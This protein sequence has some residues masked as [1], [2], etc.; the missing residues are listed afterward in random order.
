M[1]A[2]ERDTLNQ[3]GRTRQIRAGE[4]LFWQGD[5]EQ[6]VANVISGVMKVTSATGDGREQ[7]LGILYP[8][9]FVG[10]PF[11]SGNAVTVTALTDVEV[12]TFARA[13]FDAFARDHPLLEHRLLELTFDEL[14]RAREWMLLL[15]RKSADERLAAFLLHISDRLRTA[16]ACVECAGDGERFTL[17]FGR[18]QIADMLA[19]T[20][21]TVS[22]RMTVMRTKGYIDTPSRREVIIRDRRGLTMLAA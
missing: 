4:T 18:Q 9:D 10:R 15:G 20:I 19:L 6:A 21:E 14:D 16:N 2:P 17:P 3:L 12:C 13:D 1:S 8:A 11:T 22:R 7:T 5:D